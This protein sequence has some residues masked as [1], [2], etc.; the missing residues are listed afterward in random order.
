M[1]KKN[2]VQAIYYFLMAEFFIHVLW[3]R[4]ELHFY[5]AVQPRVVDDII[6]ISYAL[7]AWL[8]YALGVYHGKS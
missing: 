6:G 5:G 7:M 2:L 3:Q 8:A 4:L 1:K